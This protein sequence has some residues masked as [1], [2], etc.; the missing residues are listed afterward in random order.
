METITTANNGLSGRIPEAVGSIDGL[1]RLNLYLTGSIPAEIVLL[2]KLTNL[3]LCK[4]DSILCL[5]KKICF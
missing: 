3:D 5:K 4:S 2:T 1:T